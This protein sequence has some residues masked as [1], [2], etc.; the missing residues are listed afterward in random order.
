MEVRK[1]HDYTSTPTHRA[2]GLRGFFATAAPATH[3]LLRVAV[4]LLFMQHGVQKLFGW[5]GGIGGEGASAPLVSLMGLAGILELFGGAL[6]VLGL[7]T[8]PMAILLAVEMVVAYFMAHLPQGGFPV[9]N[10]GELA[11]LYAATFVFLFGNG[12]GP[13]SI[14]H[15][16]ARR[17]AG[18]TA[19]ESR[20]ETRTAET[21]RRRRDTAA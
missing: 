8:R 4:A 18:E 17:R 6:I 21:A 2:S 7:L 19:V 1:K 14:D 3:V 13:F 12:A 20:T 5:L 10:Q 15:W 9:Q 16:M 11:L